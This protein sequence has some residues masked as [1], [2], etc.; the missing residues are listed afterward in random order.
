MKL[1]SEPATLKD[2]IAV[3]LLLREE[4]R[5]E[6]VAARGVD[7]P[8]A[9]LME[10]MEVSERTFVLRPIGGREPNEPVALL[11]A[12][13]DPS[14]PGRAFVWLLATNAV[15]RCGVALAKKVDAMLD[16]FGNLHYPNGFLALAWDQNATHL[17]WLNTM[18][19]ATADIPAVVRNGHTF[20]WYIRPC[21]K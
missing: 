9:A 5:D 17:R 14:C 3:A 6:L 13:A 16:Y 19:F 18:G 21:V 7:V 2:C 1:T 11:G 12:A 10:C 8:L 4:D 20:L 15:Q